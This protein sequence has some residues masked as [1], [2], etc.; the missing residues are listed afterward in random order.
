MLENLARRPAAKDTGRIGYLKTLQKGDA[1]ERLHAMVVRSQFGLS[2][3]EIAARTGW[4][5]QSVQAIANEE[6][7]NGRLKIVSSSPLLLVRQ[8][9]FDELER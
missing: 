5:D 7:K 1:H 3:E 8:K 9:S 2:Q 6:E 4:T